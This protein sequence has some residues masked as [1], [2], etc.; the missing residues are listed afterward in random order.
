MQLLKKKGEGTGLMVSGSIAH[1]IG[2]IKCN[3]AQKRQ[4]ED[5]RR[6]RIAAAAAS[7]ARGAGRGG[8]GRGGAGRGGAGRGAGGRARERK[9]VPAQAVCVMAG[10]VAVR[11]PLRPCQHPPVLTVQQRCTVTLTWYT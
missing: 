10:R 3:A 6:A 9:G 2:F 1:N 11:R 5:H 4:A 8:A 7:M